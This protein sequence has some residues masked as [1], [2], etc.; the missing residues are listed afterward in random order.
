MKLKRVGEGEYQ[1][2]DG[3]VVIRRVLDASPLGRRKVRGTNPK[4]LVLWQLWLDGKDKDCQERKADAVAEAEA[5]LSRNP[6]APQ[7]G[8]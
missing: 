3:R 5:Y 2:E 4:P 7:G 6:T 8:T 1:S